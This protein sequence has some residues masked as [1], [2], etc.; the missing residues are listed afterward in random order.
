MEIFSLIMVAILIALTAFFV[1]SEFAIVKIRKSRVETLVEQGKPGAKA[2]DK[3]T[4]NLDGYLAACQLGITVTALGI[5]WLGEPAV[6]HLLH[7]VISSIG[8]SDAM[9]HT[10]SFIIA[11]GIITFL[12]V[13][14]GELAPKAF[15]IQKTEAVSLLLSPLLVIFYKVMYP[16]IWFLN[17]SARVLVG[18]FGLPPATESGE[19][20]SEEEVRSILST[21]HESGE[22]N[23]SEMSYL[24]NVFE[25][26]ERVAKE[27]MIPRT[28]IVCIYNDNTYEENLDIIRAEKY[29]R[30]PVAD[31]DKDFIIG[32]VNTKEFFHGFLNQKEKDPK[33]YIKPIIHV[34]ENTPVNAVLTKMQK[35]HSYI[36]IV[37][38]EYGGTAGLITVEDIIEEIFGEIQDELDIDEKPMFQ[39][40]DEDTVLLNGKLLI[41]ETN[42]ILN[43]QISDEELDTI[44]GWFLTQK[45]EA[46]SGTTIEYD[47]YQFKAKE[48]DGHQI[49]L[50]EVKRRNQKNE[51]RSS[52]DK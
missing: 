47:N 31:G 4:S 10:I 28:E 41:S 7:P 16:F 30:Y 43:T 6:A 11:F 9:V 12:H 29:T 26:D 38:D 22:I 49:K 40:I 39:R 46:K 21:S 3:V 25:F 50:I 33:S 17:G 32:V 20:Y 35:E 23:A 2:V 44:G 13:V 18:M 19:V 34:A 24:N 1:A 51:K 27:I 15:S 45:V 52:P 8:L 5:G 37:V 36:A 42:E 48:V 14:V